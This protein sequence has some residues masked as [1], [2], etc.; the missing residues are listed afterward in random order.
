VEPAIQAEL[1]ILDFD[2]VLC[3]AESFTP[4]AIRLG[5]RR[6]GERVG[7]AMPEP[8][9]ATLLATLGYASRQTYPP[10]IPEPVRERWREMHALT[11]DAMEER[12]R[13]LGPA[14]LYPGV[15]A[16]LDALVAAGH[17]LALASNSSARYQRVHSEVH[18][19][20]R[21]FRYLYHAECEGIATKAD[22]VAQ[23]L[24]AE[25]GARGAVMVGDRLSD[26]LA[27]ERCGLPFIACTY[28]FGCEEEWA[29]ALVRV[30]SPAALG[31]L[32]GIA[33]ADGE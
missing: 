1:I 4:E 32:F 23:V 3:R 24:A 6:F 10:L 9:E 25:P 5:L 16:L 27:A 28:G 19:L 31:A 21:W 29:G 11:L 8:D 14:V 22:M 30:D 13:A 2:G 15:P 26:R 20:P 17:V 12:I 33:P 7:V 18:G